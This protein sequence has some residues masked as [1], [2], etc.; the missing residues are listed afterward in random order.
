VP[1]DIH[2]GRPA[3]GQRVLDESI[4]ATIDQLFELYR[5]E[6]ADDMKAR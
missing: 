2:R 1:T 4:N 6:F 5:S 3:F